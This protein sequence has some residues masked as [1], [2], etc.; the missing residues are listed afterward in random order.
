MLSH[1][2]KLHTALHVYEH[3]LLK[4]IIL[5]FSGNITSFLGSQTN[6]N[7]PLAYYCSKS[8]NDDKKVCN[9]KQLKDEDQ[10][11][12]HPITECSKHPSSPEHGLKLKQCKPVPVDPCRPPPIGMVYLI[13]Y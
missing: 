3:N 1:C 13:K 10:M 5:S 8:K 6:F 2:P 7:I 4:L 12:S 11:K 9:K